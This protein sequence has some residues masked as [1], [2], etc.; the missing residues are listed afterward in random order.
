MK[1]IAYKGTVKCEHCGYIS[2][3]GYQDKDKLCNNCN[4]GFFRF[5]CYEAWNFVLDYIRD[6]M[7]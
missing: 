4:S 7:K 3:Y 2:F 6:I 1:Y 5:F